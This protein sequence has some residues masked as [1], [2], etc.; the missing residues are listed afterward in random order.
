MLACSA[1]IVNQALSWEFSGFGKKKKK[2]IIICNKTTTFYDIQYT[3]DGSQYKVYQSA[4]NKHSARS[5]GNQI[6]FYNPAQIRKYKLNYYSHK[7]YNFSELKGGYFDLFHD[8]K[9]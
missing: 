2:S 9:K 3:L 7:R 1:G 5:D 6:T 8:K 4:C